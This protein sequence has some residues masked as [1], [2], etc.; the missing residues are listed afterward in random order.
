MGAFV[1]TSGSEGEKVNDEPGYLREVEIFAWG[2]FLPIFAGKAGSVD[3]TGEE[4]LILGNIGVKS[5]A[6]G[7]GFREKVM[8]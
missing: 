4:S 8:V 3:G 2:I 6:V 5:A 1:D 7:A